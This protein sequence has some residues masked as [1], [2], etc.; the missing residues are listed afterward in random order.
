MRGALKNLGRGWVGG[1]VEQ[2]SADR[3]DHR[4]ALKHFGLGCGA[5][6]NEV[7]RAGVLRDIGQSDGAGVTVRVMVWSLRSS[8]SSIL[9]LDQP[10]AND[11]GQSRLRAF[12]IKENEGEWRFRTARTPRTAHFNTLSTYGAALVCVYTFKKVPLKNQ[13]QASVASEISFSYTFSLSKNKIKEG[14]T[15]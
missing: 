5:R 13:K 8:W 1:G 12:P 6:L 2:L 14:R 3:S 11:A 9:K 10:S 4:F 15:V 7:D